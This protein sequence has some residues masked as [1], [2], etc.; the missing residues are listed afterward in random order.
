MHINLVR[1]IHCG[2]PKFLYYILHSKPTFCWNVHSDNTSYKL[3]FYYF[4]VSIYLC[5]ISFIWQLFICVWCQLWPRWNFR[6]LSTAP[7][8][9]ETAGICAIPAVVDTR[10]FAG[11]W[12]HCEG[13]VAYIMTSNSCAWGLLPSSPCLPWHGHHMV[14]D[15]DGIM[16]VL[17]IVGA[18]VLKRWILNVLFTLA[19]SLKCLYIQQEWKLTVIQWWHLFVKLR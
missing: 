1:V 11:V 10:R 12:N 19:W 4:I 18:L 17:L 3:N 15:M 9:D 16:D 7:S 2:Y 8:F 13:S 6:V 14:S 5:L